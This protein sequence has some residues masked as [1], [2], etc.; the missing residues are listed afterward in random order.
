MDEKYVQ[1]LG[2]VQSRYVFYCD[3]QSAIHFAKNSF[4]HEKAKHINVMYHWIG[5]VLDSK[6][7]ELEKVHIDDNGLDIM[8]TKSV[9]E[10]A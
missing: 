1:E 6:L 7:L 3:S 5:H 10:E 2:F 4:F 9:K 8:L